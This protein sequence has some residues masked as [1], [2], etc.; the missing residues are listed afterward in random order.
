MHADAKSLIARLLVHRYLPRDDPQIRVLLTDDA[1]YRSVNDL[2][3][4]CGLELAEHPFAEY[5][6]TRVK[7]ETEQTVFAEEESWLSN[8][9]GLARDHVALLMVLWALLILPKRQRQLERQTG[10]EAASQGEMFGGGGTVPQASELNVDVAEATL[11]ADFAKG[12]GGK[13]R[14]NFGLGVL[15]RLGFIERRGGRIH[16]GPLL[17]LAIDYSRVAPRVMDGALAEL[18]GRRLGAAGGN[19]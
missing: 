6:A 9:L 8:N 17:D 5:V 11:Y 19:A 7:R 14:I 13:T 10:T 4:A 2:L 16:E 18:F 15:A 1:F 3:S 12:L